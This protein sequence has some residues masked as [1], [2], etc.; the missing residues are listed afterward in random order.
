MGAVESFAEEASG[1]DEEDPTLSSLG[2]VRSTVG[3]SA[4]LAGSRNSVSSHE[5]TGSSRLGS[6]R[7]NR[8]RSRSFSARSRSSSPVDQPSSRRRYTVDPPTRPPVS[9]KP[10][11]RRVRRTRR[12]FGPV[13]C[14]S[15]SSSATL[16]APA[17]GRQPSRSISLVRRSTKASSSSRTPGSMGGGRYSASSR[18]QMPFARS[19]AVRAP[20]SCHV[21]KLRQSERIGR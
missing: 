10:L 1:G 14:S 16:R 15:R 4:R 21:S 9:T 6:F 12:T 20:S 5:A 19:V 13:R 18:F 2:E 7:P 8:P 11:S 17:A 3:S